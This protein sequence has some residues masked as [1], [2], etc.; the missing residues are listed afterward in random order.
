MQDATP[1]VIRLAEYHPP[2]HLI[3]DVALTF[4]LAPRSTRLPSTIRFV[5]NPARPGAQYL[6]L[7]G[8]KLQLISAKIDGKAVALAPDASGLTLPARLLPEGPF[9]WEAE[10]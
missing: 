7:D 5:P 4:R 1:Q 2:T 8:E 10:V 6:R 9:I 3:E